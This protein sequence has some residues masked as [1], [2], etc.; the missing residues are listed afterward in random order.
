MRNEKKL[1]AS[2]WKFQRH[3]APSGAPP[4]M[5]PRETR[6]RSFSFGVFQVKFTSSSFSLHQPHSHH[7]VS[8]M[9]ASRNSVIIEA[10]HSARSTSVTCVVPG[11]TA[12]W[13]RGR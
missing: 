5:K 8:G 3:H 9:G 2:C 7:F 6:Q 1:L 10:S 11:S 13:E 12:S 4:G